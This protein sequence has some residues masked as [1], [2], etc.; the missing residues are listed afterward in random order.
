M[1]ISNQLHR[2]AA[3]CPNG[4]PFVSLYLNTQANQHGRDDFDRFLRKELSTRAKSFAEGSRNREVFERI[5]TRITAFLKDRLEVA[6][7]GLAIFASAGSSSLFEAIQLDA[8]IEKNTIH[9]L[10]RP[11]LY[12]LARVIDQYPRYVALILD[13]TR[14]RLFVFSLGR[15]RLKTEIPNEYAN[16]TELGERDHYQHT[17]RGE[18]QRTFFL[19]N[20]VEKLER[21]INDEQA[22][23]VVLAG[24][25]VIIPP[26]QELLNPEVEEKV[27]DIL[28]LDIN[29]PEHEVLRLTMRSLKEHNTHSDA[30]KVREVLDRYSSGGTAVVGLRDTIYAL[31][32]GQ[33]QELL[34]SASDE[35]IQVDRETLDQIPSVYT[36]PNTLAKY[37]SRTHSSELAADLLVERALNTKAAVTFIEDP[38]LLRDFGGVAA[39]LRYRE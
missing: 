29:T 35:E 22:A 30:E 4:S 3:H 38:L 9:V 13:G 5:A 10:D 32:E 23:H 11:F 12:P 18:N 31:S 26:L 16:Q 37:A 34:I 21:A 1:A 33:V 20:V 39:L 36:T 8:P 14:A 7:N 19:K 15:T 25:E 27:I 24:D 28:R 17:R 2:L 6:T